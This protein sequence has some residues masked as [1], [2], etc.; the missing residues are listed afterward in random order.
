MNSV[1]AESYSVEPSA[2]RRCLDECP[3][4][5]VLLSK[6]LVGIQFE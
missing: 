5:Y 6:E 4:V 1:I 2:E 3:S